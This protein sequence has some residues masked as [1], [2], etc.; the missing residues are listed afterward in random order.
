VKLSSVVVFVIIISILY[1]IHI[2]PY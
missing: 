1:H 2:I